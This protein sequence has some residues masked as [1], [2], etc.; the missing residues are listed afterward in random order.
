MTTLEKVKTRLYFVGSPF[1]AKDAI[2]SLGGH[3]DADRRQWWIGSAKQ[4]D[5]GSLVAQI[6]GTPAPTN[7]EP[8]RESAKA[9]S[10]VGLDA[11]TPA[12]IVADK[13]QDAGQDAKAAVIRKPKEDPHTIRLTGKGRYKGREY[14]AGAITRDGTRVRLLTLPDTNGDY[15]DFWADCSQVEQT[16]T[17]KPREK[18]NGGRGRWSDQILVYTTLGSIADF[19]RRQSDPTR[20]RRMQCMECGAWHDAD[21]VCLECGGC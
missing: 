7:R 19:I 4:A 15:L 18:W 21:Q 12:D 5:A 10:T 13:L 16:K 11:D 14:Y 6:N 17:Y 2:K 8:T 1:T 20:V 3:W 9:A